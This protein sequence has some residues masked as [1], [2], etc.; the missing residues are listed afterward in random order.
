M[1]QRGAKANPAVPLKAKEAAEIVA[2]GYATAFRHRQQ[3]S[4]RHPKGWPCEAAK[5]TPRNWVSKA[6]PAGPSR[7]LNQPV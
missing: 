4:P 5:M 6:N 7:S 3:C 2:F 1:G